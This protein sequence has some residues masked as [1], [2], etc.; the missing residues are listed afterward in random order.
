MI[1]LIGLGWMELLILAVLG[2]FFVGAAVAILLI[3]AR[4]KRAS[5]VP[6]GKQLQPCP[7]CGQMLSPAAITCPGCGHPLKA[8]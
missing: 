5:A 7:E 1:G 6:P 2:M 4:G 3:V 8:I